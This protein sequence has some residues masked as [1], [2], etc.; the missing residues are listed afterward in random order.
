MKHIIIIIQTQFSQAR[1]T[2]IKFDDSEQAQLTFL[3]TRPVSVS[4]HLRFDIDRNRL[5]LDDRFLLDL[6]FLHS[7]NGDLLDLRHLFGGSLRQLTLGLLGPSGGSCRS[8]RPQRPTSLHRSWRHCFH[9]FVE[10]RLELLKNWE[11]KTLNF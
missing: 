6:D 4:F 10:Q 9:N 2:Q 3:R 11:L 7:L 5:F 8:P 1:Q